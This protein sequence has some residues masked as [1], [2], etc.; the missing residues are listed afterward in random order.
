[1]LRHR[2]ALLVRLTRFPEY[3]WFVMVT[4]LLG[5]A[6]GG[7]TVGWR[8]VVVVLANWLAVGFAF[9]INDVEDA[10]DDAL[11][12]AK[13]KRN[14][15]STG[16]VSAAR[17]RAA[18]FLVAML[19]AAGYAALGLLPLV[20][21]V[22]CLTLAFLYSW[23]RIRLKS[24]PGAD[25][26]SHALLLAGLQFLAAYLSFEAEQAWHWILPLTFLMA[27]S[28]YGQL[29]NELRDLDGD[30]RAGVVHTASV[31]GPRTAHLLMFFWLMVG[32]AS[33]VATILVTRLVPAWVL[34]LMAGLAALLLVRPMRRV[35]R[36]RGRLLDI[37]SHQPLQK[38]IEAAGALSLAAWFAAPW[39]LAAGA[40]YLAPAAEALTA[41]LG[42][43]PGP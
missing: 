12:P 26:V 16:E 9:M 19:A 1:M 4:T 34:I 24:I 38:P 36:Q 7:A 6:A 5:A 13:L 14:P 41:V 42:R 29:F 39:A 11:T 20:T 40:R 15:V 21:G 33:A 37:H 18:A 10:P 32:G 30:R 27:V 23:R 31:L 3:V 25:L 35:R 28:I 2:L 22:A 17:A 8:L 43:L